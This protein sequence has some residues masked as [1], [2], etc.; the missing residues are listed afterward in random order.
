MAGGHFYLAGARLQQATSHADGA[1]EMY[2]YLIAVSHEP[3]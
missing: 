1:D 3:T 2:T